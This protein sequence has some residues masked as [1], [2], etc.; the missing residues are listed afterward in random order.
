MIHKSLH[1]EEDMGRL[2]NS[3]RGSGWFLLTMLV[4]LLCLVLPGPLIAQEYGSI[5]GTVYNADGGI[6]FDQAVYVQVVHGDPCGHWE[7]VSQLNIPFLP[8][9]CNCNS[10][11]IFMDI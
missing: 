8:I 9:F 7:A 3:I 6:P 2:S 11:R 5:S 10:Y 1:K 4:F